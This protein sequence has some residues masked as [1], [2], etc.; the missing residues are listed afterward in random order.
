MKHDLVEFR[1]TIF[2][3]RLQIGLVEE[4]RIAQ[5][6]A[7]NAFVA[8]DDG[9]AA[10]GGF[11]IRREDELVGELARPGIAHH[12]TFLVGADRCADHFVGDRQEV[13]IER[14]HQ[15]HR[16]FDQARHFIEQCGVFD[17][18]EAL[19]ESELARVGK[20]D[21]LAALGIE[22][23]LG[24]LQFCDVVVEAAHLDL[25]GGEEAMT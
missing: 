8:G 21:L 2:Q 4:F 5:A 18:L 15:H 22:H 9:G 7:D 10:I 11:D 3:L 25:A 1:Q 14:A 23:D 12:E 24:L 19:R 16:P 6:R 20:D 17:Q 13:R